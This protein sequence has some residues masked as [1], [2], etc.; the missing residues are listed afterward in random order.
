MRRRRNVSNEVIYYS[1]I[2]VGQRRKHV[3]ASCVSAR[4]SAI[5][6]GVTVSLTPVGS[7]IGADVA[8]VD[9]MLL[10]QSLDKG[11]KSVCFYLPQR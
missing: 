5:S 3:C 4:T 9:Y 1:A 8:E 11:S 7:A 2:W 6:D 10:V